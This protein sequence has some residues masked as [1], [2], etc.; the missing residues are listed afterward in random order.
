M[1]SI[2][3][4][5]ISIIKMIFEIIKLK[6]IAI[7]IVRPRFGQAASGIPLFMT[8]MNNRYPNTRVFITNYNSNSFFKE[9]LKKSNCNFIENKKLAWIVNFIFNN[10]GF[11]LIRSYSKNYFKNEVNTF[12]KII[13]NEK[14]INNIIE[15]TRL[16]VLNNFDLNQKFICLSI[17]EKEY[18]DSTDVYKNY[19]NPDLEFDTIERFQII[20]NYFID[21]GYKVVRMGRNLKKASFEIDGFFDYASSE[22]ASD[23]NDVVFSQKC[24][25]VFSNQTGFDFLP[26]YWFSKPIY[27]Y[28]IRYYRFIMEIFPF[29]SFNPVKAMKNDKYLSYKETMELESKLW[30]NVDQ[31]KL[32]I[33]LNNS[34]IKYLLYNVEEIL[35][36]AKLFLNDYEKNIKSTE[37]QILILKKDIDLFWENFNFYL[38]PYYTKFGRPSNKKINYTFPNLDIL[39]YITNE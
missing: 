32:H 2:F 30:D 7:Y 24:E 18:Y 27:I 36:S 15:T 16:N 33:I 10:L 29:R 34:K 14:I 12:D 38:K 11:N 28:Q 5:L 22:I 8:E 3:N 35:F 6:K 37:N 21:S 23:L 9:Y 13:I 31:N 39:K 25:F 20:I 17:K 1:K 26:A 4:D 19:R